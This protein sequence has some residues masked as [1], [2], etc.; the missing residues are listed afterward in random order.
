MYQ[1]YLA[2]KLSFFSL[3]FCTIYFFAHS[4]EIAIT[5]DDAPLGDGNHY[6]GSERTDVL[7]KKLKKL[8]ID[9]V[10]FFSTTSHI[11]S[12]EK[13]Q[14]LL[15][16]AKAGHLLANHTHTHR[17]IKVLGT[18]GY[19]QD[20]QQ[21][22]QLLET[23]PNFRPW[24]RFPFLD[25]GRTIPT[26]DSLRQALSALG[27]TN[28]YVTV[29]NYDWYI[30][31][32]FQQALA[33]KKKLDYTAL[34]TMYITHIWESIQFYHRMAIQNLE[35]SPRHVLLL[36][37]N[38]LAALFIDDLVKHIRNQGWKII[39]P[40]EA[41]QDPIASHIPD[42]LLNG[43]GRVAAIAK[44]KGYKGP[45]VQDSEDEEYLDKLFSQMNIVK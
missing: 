23:M 41:Y 2:M 38:D 22:H 21:A 27:Y 10:A 26:R 1:Y 29:D 5:F 18:Q 4:Q 6:S 14:R 28:G 12:D 7:I 3:L 37:E 24:F 16:Y 39:S 32:L 36:H 42:V 40:T 15:A 19:I 30:N 17:G 20:I 31:S 34:K 9:E 43:Q 25:E 11:D 33:Q 8:N 35:R 45:F 13:K 44:E